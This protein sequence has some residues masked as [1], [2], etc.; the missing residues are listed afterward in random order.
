[1]DAI[2]LLKDDHRTVEDVFGRYEKAGDGAYQEKRHL[3]DRMVKELSVHASIE[4]EIFYPAT[5]EAR[6]ETEEMVKEAYEEHA[7]TK[8]T[9]MQLETM[10]PEAPQFDQLVRTLMA[11][12][13]H[14]VEEEEGEMFPKVQQA[15]PKEQLQDLGERMKEAKKSAPQTPSEAA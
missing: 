6:G 5:R 13:R 10:D 14:H 11:D 4:E 9:L 15:L 3:V 2:Q 7:K 1:M 8:Q 12:V